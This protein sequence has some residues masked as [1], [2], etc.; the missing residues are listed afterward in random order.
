M[1]KSILIFVLTVATYLQA[2]P[3]KSEVWTIGPMLHFNFGNKGI[4]ASY[5]LE[6]AY[7]NYEHFP[8]SVDFGFEFEKHKFRM[9]SEAQT[10]IGVLGVSLG[11]VL[12]FGGEDHKLKC[13]IQGSGW[14]NYFAG[15]DLRF[16]YVG[17]YSTVSPGIYLK[18]PMVTGDYESH[19]HYFYHHH[20][21]WDL[22]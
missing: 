15:I 8:Y 14:L 2:L 1:R 11:P 4:H 5:G 10:G 7:W 17:S 21:H 20:H 19:Y 3:Q 22:D 9:Y 6:L 18:L 12:Q 13:G 16:R